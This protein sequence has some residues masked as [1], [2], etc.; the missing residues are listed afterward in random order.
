MK[1][2]YIILGMIG[3]L[4]LVNA[5]VPQAWASGFTVPVG[6]P[7]GFHITWAVCILTAI[8]IGGIWK[9]KSA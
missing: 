2:V 9:L 4:F 8:L 5:Y 6:G 3:A 1:W 7:Q